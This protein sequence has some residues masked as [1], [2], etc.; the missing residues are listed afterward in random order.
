MKKQIY[1][2]M[3]ILAIV[4]CSSMA[5]ATKSINGTVTIGGATNTFT[6]S[7]KVGMSVTATVAAYT[8]TSCHLNGSFQY[9]TVGGTGTTQDASKIYKAPFP[10]Q[11]STLYGTPTVTDTAI[12]LPTAVTWAE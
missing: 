12:T 11:S 6:P 10:S 4:G 5:H 1:K 8:A 7:A 2:V 3:L 9:G